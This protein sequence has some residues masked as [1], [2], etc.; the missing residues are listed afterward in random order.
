MESWHSHSDYN[1][2]TWAQY[3]LLQQQLVVCTFLVRTNSSNFLKYVLI[4][5]VYNYGLRGSP[6]PKWPRRVE[7]NWT[8]SKRDSS[9]NSTSLLLHTQRF[10]CRGCTVYNGPGVHS[11]PLSWSAGL[12]YENANFCP[13]CSNAQDQLPPFSAPCLDPNIPFFPQFF[14]TCEYLLSPT[15]YMPEASSIGHSNLN[16]NQL[17]F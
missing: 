15:T 14:H 2:K 6:P 8:S 7:E 3:L 9:Q 10:I 17:T 11:N 4:K 13:C 16:F 5:V 1:L 12:Q